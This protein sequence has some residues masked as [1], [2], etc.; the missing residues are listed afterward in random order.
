MKPDKEV[1]LTNELLPLVSTSSVTS[2][3]DKPVKSTILDAPVGLQ[4]I[5]VADEVADDR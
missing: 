5:K 2:I 1:M 4:V 3:K